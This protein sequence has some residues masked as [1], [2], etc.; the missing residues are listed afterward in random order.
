MDHVALYKEIKTGKYK[1]VYLLHG[2]EA[3][4]IDNIAAYIEE[5]VLTPA[6]KDFNC[7]IFYG[8]DSNP[9]QVMDACMRFPMFAAYNLV[10][11]REAQMMK[12]RGNELDL[13]EKYVAHPSPT[14]ILVICYKGGKYDARKKLM[15]QCKEQ[16][17]VFESALLKEEQ[18]PAFIE[19]ALARRKVQAE[20]KAVQLLVDY[21][22]TDLARINNELEKLCINLTEGEKITTALIEK[23]IGI[24]KDFNVYELQSA[25]LTKQAGKA[26]RIV[27]FMS[28][29]PKLHP[30]VLTMSNVHAAF[31]KL[32][33]MHLGGQVPDKL[34]WNTYQI[35]SS[36][37]GDYKQAMR[38]YSTERV[39]DVFGIILEYDLRNK[40]VHND[41]TNEEELLRE[42]VYRIIHEE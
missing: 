3:Y 31:Q 11:V 15:R 36:Q 22:G 27:T 34:L 41:Q 2:E 8:K 35:H 19:K 30:F 4:Y 10:I 23:N 14:T 5:T 17:I 33:H 18:I 38:H 12:N 6:E 29:N 42:M 39:E 24:S 21:L 7:H 28:E 13:I 37:A 40:G 25:L 26:F 9:Q 1:P 16:G 32:Y 20:T